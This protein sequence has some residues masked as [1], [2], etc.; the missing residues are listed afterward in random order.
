MKSAFC[1]LAFSLA[2]V[3]CAVAPAQPPVMD[4]QTLSVAKEVPVPCLNAA[5]VPQPSQALLADKDLLSGTG[6]Q[7]ADKLWVDHMVRSD[8]IGDLLAVM[9]KCETLPVK[10]PGPLK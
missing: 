5:D 1:A 9:L 10:Q 7:V 2:L 6:S 3:A 8:Y 4:T